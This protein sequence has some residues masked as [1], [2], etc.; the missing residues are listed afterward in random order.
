MN[1]LNL[2][3]SDTLRLVRLLAMQKKRCKCRLCRFFW[4]GGMSKTEVT[5]NYK[6]RDS[7]I[8]AYY[9]PRRPTGAIALNFGVRRHSADII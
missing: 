7:Y 3:N 9:L 6:P 2:A 5:K 8:Y 1:R 4:G